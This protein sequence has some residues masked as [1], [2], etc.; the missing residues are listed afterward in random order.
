MDHNPSAEDELDPFYRDGFKDL[1]NGT[2]DNIT[3]AGCPALA[4]LGI[5]VWNAWR[6]D[7]P[8]PRL[9]LGQ[10]ENTADFSGFDFREESINFQGFVFDGVARFDG[11]NFARQVVCR[12]QVGA[13]L[14]I[15]PEPSS[16]LVA[17][18]HAIVFAD[19]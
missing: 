15:Q 6:K 17:R 7:N 13:R 18:I 9:I 16:V 8:A 1:K 4:Q 10:W 3:Q 2:P 11:A 14:R 19:L 5:K 12:L